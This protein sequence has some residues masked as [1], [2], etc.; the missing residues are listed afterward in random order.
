MAT[1]L[2]FIINFIII[3]FIVKL[4]I[5]K[6][7]KYIIS[8]FTIKE[9]SFNYLKKIQH[10]INRIVIYLNV[11]FVFAVFGSYIKSISQT[12]ITTIIGIIDFFVIIALGIFTKLESSLNK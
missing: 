11:I 5:S 4:I 2:I 3:F 8:K 9:D 10:R 6:S 1:A 7:S 12:T